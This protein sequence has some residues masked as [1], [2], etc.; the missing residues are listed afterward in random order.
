VT[1]LLIAAASSVGLILFVTF[2]A[3][4][5]IRSRT[6]GLSVRLQVFLALSSIE[7]AF[8]FGLGR[9]VVDRV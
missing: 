7:L 1:R 9:L 8:A 6:R 3:T 4:R 5:L 2:I